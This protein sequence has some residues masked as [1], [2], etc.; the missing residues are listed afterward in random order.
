MYFT[1]VAILSLRINYLYAVLDMMKAMRSAPVHDTK[2]LFPHI[3]RPLQC[4]D[5][6]KVLIAPR[7]GKLVI[8][9]GVVDG[10]EGEVVSLWL[11]ELGLL[12]ISQLLLV[13][14]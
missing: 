12:L 10:E 2:H 13:L 9:P 14:N 8:L 11:V 4:P 7:I 6:H 3:L 1:P 5:L